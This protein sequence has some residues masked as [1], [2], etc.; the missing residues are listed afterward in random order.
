MCPALSA[1]FRKEL[2][3]TKDP[4]GFSSYG[5]RQTSK[6]SRARSRGSL[7]SL[8]AEQI[9]YAWQ[10]SDLSAAV[11]EEVKKPQRTWTF[12]FGLHI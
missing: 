2:I 3:C 12:E 9:L 11:H 8:D 4:S 6:S 1:L 7:Y 10:E 5:E